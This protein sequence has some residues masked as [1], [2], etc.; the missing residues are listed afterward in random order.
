MSPA[1]GDTGKRLSSWEKLSDVV[2][3]LHGL[4][5]IVMVSFVPGRLV[6]GVDAI[7]G[8]VGIN[9]EL[10]SKLSSLAKGSIAALAPGVKRRR[11]AWSPT[12]L[13]DGGE[14]N[15]LTGVVQIEL[16]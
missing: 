11:L 10:S 2:H 4:D 8:V 15:P 3:G 6:S 12:L 13:T 14:L 7:I 16:L 5:V 9:S 1:R